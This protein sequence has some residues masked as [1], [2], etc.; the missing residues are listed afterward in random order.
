MD[1]NNGRPMYPES[2]YR[3]WL[4]ILSP[5]LKLG[6]SLNYAVDRTE[7]G[8]HRTTLYEKYKLGDWF[9]DEVDRLT[10]LPGEIA[11]S[12][13]V[14][15]VLGIDEKVKQGQPLTS[16][17]YRN[18]RFFAEKHRSCKAFFVTRIE[19]D[20]PNPKDIGKLLDTIEQTDYDELARQVGE[21]SKK[22]D[23][24]NSPISTTAVPEQSISE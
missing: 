2:Q 17:E 22:N 16:E 6:N 13:F 12:I 10:S 20:K 23:N 18:L 8:H 15:I 19:T 11:N 9:S 24:Q 7:L 3:T 4:E 1:N 14:R 5:Y 21:F